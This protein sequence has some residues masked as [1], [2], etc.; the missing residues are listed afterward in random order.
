MATATVSVIRHWPESKEINKNGRHKR[1]PVDVRKIILHGDFF[2]VDCYT[3]TL[4]KRHGERYISVKE[5]RKPERP[6]WDKS[7]IKEEEYKWA[8]EGSYSFEKF[9]DWLRK[10]IGPSAPVF[11][12][13]MLTSPPENM[14]A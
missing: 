5:R 4:V 7:P 13:D 8:K 12:S 6:W 3:C 10:R 9:E 14:A 1:F 11:I 2:S